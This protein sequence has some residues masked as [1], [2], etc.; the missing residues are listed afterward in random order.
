MVHQSPAFKLVERD[1]ELHCTAFVLG[2]SIPV[3]SIFAQRDRALAGAH[4][5][6]L[7]DMRRS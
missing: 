6:W 7:R 1:G 5:M 3:S 4:S 2:F